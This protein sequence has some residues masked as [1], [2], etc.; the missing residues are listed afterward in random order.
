MTLPDASRTC[1]AGRLARLAK[2]ET[3]DEIAEAEALFLKWRAKRR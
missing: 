1:V 2:R 3:A